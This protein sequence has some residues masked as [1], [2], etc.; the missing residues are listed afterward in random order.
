MIDRSFL[1]SHT[2]LPPPPQL[3]Q[4]KSQLLIPRHNATRR[5][6][7][8]RSKKKKKVPCHNHYSNWII[9]S[10]RGHENRFLMSFSSTRSFYLLRLLIATRTKAFS[11]FGGFSFF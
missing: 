9:I 3:L 10:E 1:V 8:R 2:H 6:K 5:K 11:R 4:S 7:G